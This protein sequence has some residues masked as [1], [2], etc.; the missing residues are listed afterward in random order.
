MADQLR[1][2]QRT[3]A[4]ID[5]KGP[6]AIGEQRW[7]DMAGADKVLPVHGRFKTPYLG[8]LGAAK[9]VVGGKGMTVA[10]YNDSAVTAFVAT[11]PTSS[12]AAPTGAADG[13]AIPPFSYHYIQMGEHLWIRSN[14]ATTYG[15]E[16]DDDTYISG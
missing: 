2:R 15:Y 14:V 11:G 13:V 16:L 4:G 8:A 6:Q 9:E 12:L 7:N 1:K 10:V 3:K 5:T